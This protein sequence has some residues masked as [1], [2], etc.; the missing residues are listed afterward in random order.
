M[1]LAKLSRA[2]GELS[3]MIE[4]G[5]DDELTFRFLIFKNKV[6]EA[7]DIVS[8]LDFKGKAHRRHFP[9]F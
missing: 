8:R 2:A 9:P 4:V 3:L 5:A 1:C 7:N 6:I